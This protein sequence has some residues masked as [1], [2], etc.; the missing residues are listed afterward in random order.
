MLD[1]LF[2]NGRFRTLDVE[3]PSA[4][5]IGVVGGVIVGVDEELD[6]CRA[7]AVYDLAGAPVVPGFN[8][9]HHHLSD[10]GL[11]LQHC[12]VSPSAVATLDELYL[13]IAQRAAQLPEDAWVVATGYDDIRLDGAPTRE[14]L[15]TAADGR[16]AWVAHR[17]YHCGVLNSEA[18]R[19]M[20]FNDLR[21][22]HDVDGGVIARH[23][24]GQPT[25]FI[26]ENAVN[27]VNEIIRPA[28]FD[29][30][31]G[32]IAAASRAAVADGLTS[33]TEPGICGVLSGN[34]PADLAAFQLARDRGVLNVRVTVMPELTALHSI[35]FDRRP[36][37]RL[38]LDLGLRTGLGDDQLR[39]GAV[40]IF[41][42][43]ALLAR[44]AALREDYSDGRGGR[45]L[46]LEEANA[47][48]DKVLAAH[49]AG[50]RLATHA[51]GDAAIDAVL[52]AYE[53]AQA[54]VPR[55]GVRHRIEHCGLT[56]DE[57]IARIKAL[58]VVPVPQG[59]FIAEFGDGYV[60]AL[61][62]ERA[63][64]LFRQ[65]GFLTAGVVVPGSSDCPVV[66]GAPLRGI[67]SLV[68]RRTATG[69]CLGP[70][71]RLTAAQALAA[72]T[73]GSAYTEHYE[74]RKG[75]LTRGSLADFVVLSDDL[76]AVPSHRIADLDVEATV[77]GG[78]IRYGA[79]TESTSAPTRSIHL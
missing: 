58:G 67:Q 16:P 71:E 27:L 17:S 78:C 29:D 72:F 37:R 35:R 40:K 14:R 8:D 2:V 46:L 9:V 52:D 48:R 28:P 32:A 11:A 25:G 42:D 53:H 66:D 70:A 49:R 7:E 68:E 12:D 39:I 54:V 33:I 41:G 47:L 10:R 65:R 21:A 63:E 50:W 62:P 26:A 59:Q 73:T 69:R 31:V 1:A 20:G 5:S 36:E 45:G 22:V 4:R 74:H 38:G 23:A 55:P 57:Q 13:A 61:G 75:R 30:F 3:R 56:H 60:D 51:I 18:F 43:G 19:R 15:D 76:L 24:D 79:L 44:T 6:G 64:L 77:V 34:G